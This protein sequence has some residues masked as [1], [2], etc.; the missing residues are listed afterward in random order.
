M[1][2][3]NQK[4]LAYT[5]CVGI[6][7]PNVACENLL[8]VE[9]DKGR[10]TKERMFSDDAVATSAMNGLYSDML[11]PAGFASGSNT[12]IT[13]W[14]GLLADELDTYS[15]TSVVN[16][17]AENDVQPENARVLSLWSSMYR[18][19]YQANAVIEGVIASTA[20]TAATREELEGEARLVRAFCYF[21]LIN[22][23]GEVPLNLTTDYRANATAARNSLADIYQQIILDLDIAEAKLSPEY[24]VAAGR[25]R[26]IRAAASAL[27]AR[28][29]L[30]TERWM[31]A[32][33]NA[34][35]VIE[36]EKFRLVPLDE[37]FKTNNLEAIWQLQPVES[38]FTN[39]GYFFIILTN[40]SDA[41]SYNALRTDFLASFEE[42]DARRDRWVSSYSDGEDTWY[43]PYKY[44]AGADAVSLEESSSVLRL[45]EQYLIRAEARL[46]NGNNIGAMADVDSIRNRAGL[47]LVSTSGTVVTAD[48][49]FSLI[50]HERRIEMFAEWGHR[51]L[52]L[53]RLGAL[54]STIGSIKPG[55]NDGDELLPIPQE[56]RNRNPFLGDQNRGYF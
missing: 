3:I 22:F 28:I 34:T 36:D 29:A 21:Y 8:D 6:L 55:W 18:S 39:E 12:S 4:I 19:I 54:P 17:F 10:I 32:E 52:D 13:S 9:L 27:K 35:K 1:N 26:P 23:F 46:R 5:L 14:S 43:Y 51:W 20:L 24:N 7:A 48:S 38:F 45:A 44:K 53:K 2:M 30:F 31:D 16:E 15:P 42:G 40:P 49:L 11:D 47:P 33:E 25:V 37:A 50:Q 41:V 56:E